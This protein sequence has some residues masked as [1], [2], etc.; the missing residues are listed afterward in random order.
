MPQKSLRDAWLFICDG[1]A[2]K[3]GADLH[4][5]AT[6][7]IDT[8]MWLAVK[9]G[10]G[11][12]SWTEARGVTY[13]LDRGRLV[14]L[15]ADGSAEVFVGEAIRG[16]EQP[17][18][19]SFDIT[20]EDY[21]QPA[22]SAV[23]GP[24]EAIKGV[25]GALTY[26]DGTTKP[27]TLVSD[28]AASEIGDWTN[29]DPDACN[30]WSVHLLVQFQPPCTGYTE[31]LWFPRFRWDQMQFNMSDGQI[32]CSGKCT[33]LKPISVPDDWAADNTNWNLN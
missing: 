9:V 8:S 2:V 28:N 6:H 3:G 27:L 19:V 22:A 17:M 1:V 23:P 30:P 18:E 24:V 11:N 10:E 25:N 31:V 4:T 15:S 21:V 26:P 16:D 12:I 7:T 20:F 14:D 13:K 5:E 32:S 29:A 33:A